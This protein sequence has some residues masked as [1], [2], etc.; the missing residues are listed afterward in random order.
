MS[1][2]GASCSGAETVSEQATCASGH[3]VISFRFLA[4]TGRRRV[5][6]PLGSGDRRVEARETTECAGFQSYIQVP[7]S[8]CLIGSYESLRDPPG[9]GEPGGSTPSSY[10]VHPS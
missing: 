10:S 3:P 7:N 2:L 4:L 1:P 6:V 8:V 9:A 5:R